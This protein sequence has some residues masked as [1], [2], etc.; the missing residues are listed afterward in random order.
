MITIEQLAK[1]YNISEVT[2]EQH[3][4]R[5]EF[6]G[7]FTVAKMPTLVKK[8]RKGEY[9]TVERNRI[10]ISK[11]KID[12]YMRLRNVFAK[13]KKERE[14][15]TLSSVQCYLNGLDCSKCDNWDIACKNATRFSFDKKTPMK[16]IVLEIF[17]KYGKPPQYL[18][19]KIIA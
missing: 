1:E 8:N 15:W 4:R 16:K 19:E 13:H 2:I 9:H 12:E 17:K 7:I 18:I 10:C 14:D 5:K 11:N 3:S 6:Y